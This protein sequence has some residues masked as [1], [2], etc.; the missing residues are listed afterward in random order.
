MSAS[1]ANRAAAIRDYLARMDKGPAMAR[2]YSVVAARWEELRL[3]MDK[4]KTTPADDARFL[5]LSHTLKAIGSKLG[6]ADLTD[7]DG[8]LPGDPARIICSAW[9]E[10]A[11]GGDG[12]GKALRHPVTP[13][14][15]L[16]TKGG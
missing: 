6:F 11:E 12:V 16:R 5:D 4:G 7:A 8:F 15:L 14:S 2:R 13:N 3:A 10:A 9:Q 1:T